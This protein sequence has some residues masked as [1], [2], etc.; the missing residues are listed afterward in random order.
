MA[1]RLLKEWQWGRVFVYLGLA[2]LGHV[3]RVCDLWRRS[4]VD[5]L[6]WDLVETPVLFSAV[7]LSEFSVWGYRQTFHTLI[8]SPDRLDDPQSCRGRFLLCLSPRS[9]FYSLVR[10]TL[11][12]STLQLYSRT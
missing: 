8:L 1:A 6:S 4:A 9:E 2:D 10:S 7:N 3:R 5:R 11:T 12:Y